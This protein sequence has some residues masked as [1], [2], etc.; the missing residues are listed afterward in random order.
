MTQ[1]PYRAPVSPSVELSN[2]PGGRWLLY[3]VVLSFLQVLS[4][5]LNNAPSAFELMRVGEISF[6]T[7]LAFI[8]AN[9]AMLIGAG[10]LLWRKSRAATAVYAMSGV[11]AALVLSGWHP[12]LAYSSVGIALIGL[13]ISVRMVLQTRAA[14]AD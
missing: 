13:L 7:F 2:R 12:P 11:F 14:R 6:I 10:M 3:A 4:N 1:D 5:A 8:L 9:A